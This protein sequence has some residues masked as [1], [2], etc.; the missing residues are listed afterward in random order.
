M[1]N[2]TTSIHAGHMSYNIID[3]LLYNKNKIANIYYL[4]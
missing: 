2:T 4:Y 3:F 1:Y